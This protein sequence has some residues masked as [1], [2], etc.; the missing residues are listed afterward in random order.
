VPPPEKDSTPIRENTPGYIACCFPTL[1]PDGVGDFY[2]PRPQSVDLGDYFQHLM[3]YKDGRFARHRRFPWFAF[4]TLQRHRAASQAKIYVKQSHIAAP[5]TATD[6][7]RMLEEG[8]KSIAHNMIRYG[9]TLRGTRAYWS[10][11]RSEL[12]DAINVLGSPHAFITLSA[13]DLQWPLLHRH[14]PKECDVPD[15]DTRAEKRQRRLA[16]KNNPHI[17]ASY[18]EHRVSLFF[19]HVICPLLGVKHYWYRYEW[20]ER[21]SGHI[22]GFLW[23][24]NAPNPNEIDWDHAKRADAIIS[25]DQEQ[26]ISAFIDFWKHL[27]SAWNPFPREDENSPLLGTHP[28]AKRP[29]DMTYNKAELSELLN[30][31]QRHTKCQPGYCQVKRKV[32]GQDDPK[33]CCRFDFPKD[34]M[35]RAT[36]GVDSKNRVHFQPRRNDR[37]VN[38]YNTDLIMG[39][40]A[41]TD[42]K[43]VLSKASA[44][45]YVFCSFQH[46]DFTILILHF[47]LYI[48]ICNKGRIIRTQIPYNVTRN[49]ILSGRECPYPEHL[50]KITKQDDR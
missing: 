47:Q 44:L 45:T 50:Y 43:P 11:H 33:I 19:K 8:D 34:T 40:Q 38:N 21:G 31:V 15:G 29:E 28:C 27:I 49:S 32:P 35:E 18:L 30:W 20:Q 4:N 26:K 1:F 3:R 13:A 16:L 6:L 14:M 46:D 37:L 9:A 10:A 36:Y 48:Q 42:I 23:L 22:H 7:R 24:K 39:W 2:E 25:D 12:T 5:L 17:A 41:N